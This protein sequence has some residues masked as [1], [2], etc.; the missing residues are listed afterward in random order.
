M[1]K[2]D[3]TRNIYDFQTGDI[4]YYLGNTTYVDK[5]GPKIGTI[6]GIFAMDGQLYYDIADASGIIGILHNSLVMPIGINADILEALGFK[7]LG[8]TNSYRYE[9]VYDRSNRDYA[10]IDYYLDFP[11]N[12]SAVR[13]KDSDGANPYKHNVYNGFATCVHE[14]QHITRMLKFNTELKLLNIK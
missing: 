13:H 5:T 3:T 2:E 8:K 4:V 1:K 10:Q 6:A 14:L 12:T 7:R 11:D 9:E